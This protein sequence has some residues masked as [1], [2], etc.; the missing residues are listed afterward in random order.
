MLNQERE[1]RASDLAAFDAQAAALREENQATQ[2]FL[3]DLQAVHQG[4]VQRLNEV[5]ARADRQAQGDSFK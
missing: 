3:L 4:T 1:L 5:Q 2:R